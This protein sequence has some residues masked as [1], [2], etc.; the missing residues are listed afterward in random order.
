MQKCTLAELIDKLPNRRYI[1]AFEIEDSWV[2][3][4]SCVASLAAS[5]IAELA[6]HEMFNDA[7]STAILLQKRGIELLLENMGSPMNDV[8]ETAAIALDY[9]LTTRN[10]LRC[11]IIG[12]DLALEVLLKR[13]TDNKEGM[14]FTVSCILHSFYCQFKEDGEAASQQVI[15]YKQGELLRALLRIIPS[16]ERLSLMNQHL[17]HLKDLVHD[18]NVTSQVSQPRAKALCDAGLLGILS[19]VEEDCRVKVKEKKITT[20]E[21]NFS[22]YLCNTIRV[23]REDLIAA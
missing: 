9:L 22:Q 19:E 21:L 3:V 7:E 11:K 10:P 20:S 6:S 18:R 12:S 2:E 16:F 13:L 1:R 5:R 14:R 4:P 17:Q 15:I 23:L 8:K